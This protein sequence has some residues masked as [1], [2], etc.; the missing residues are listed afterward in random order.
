MNVSEI[1]MEFNIVAED[2]IKLVRD[3]YLEAFGR[4]TTENMVMKEVSLS[5]TKASSLVTAV[6]L[7]YC[8]ILLAK[9][10]HKSNFFEN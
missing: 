4:F 8:I 1:I 7:T 9:I 2:E 5:F 10:N 3:G 6:G